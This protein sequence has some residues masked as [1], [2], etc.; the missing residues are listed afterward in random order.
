VETAVETPQSRK[1]TRVIKG[2]RDASTKKVSNC[3]LSKGDPTSKKAKASSTLIS[4]LFI[5]IFL[6]KYL[7][8]QN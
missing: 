6:H 5:N 4:H 3:G 2:R 8:S 7:N 1:N